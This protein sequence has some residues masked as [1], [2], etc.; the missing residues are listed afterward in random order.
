MDAFDHREGAGGR[1]MKR[2]GH[3]IKALFAGSRGKRGE[4]LTEV[5]AAI[6][7]GLFALLMLAMAISVSTR[8]STESRDYMNAYYTANKNAIS[9]E[10]TSKLGEGTI[11]LS[12]SGSA[13]PVTISGD[14][15]V[16]V[17]YYGNGNVDIILYD[18]AGGGS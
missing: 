11:T 13:T 10:S 12:Q 5:L 8:I 18:K 16:D 9:N 4:S 15:A 17:E 3:S 2:F 7:I 1:M 6:T 14:D